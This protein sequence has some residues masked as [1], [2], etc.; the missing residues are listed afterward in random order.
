MNS[1]EELRKTSGINATERSHLIAHYNSRRE[2]GQE[3]RSGL[4]GVGF[5]AAC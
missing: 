1:I 4:F 3:D 5:S 2:P